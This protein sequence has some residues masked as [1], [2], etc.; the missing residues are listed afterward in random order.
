LNDPSTV[1]K[2][3]GYDV[4]PQV[5]VAGFFIDLGVR[6]PPSLARS[7]SALNATV[8]A[9]IQAGPPEIA[10]ACARKFS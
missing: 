6:I 2:E 3:K 10:T 9:I 8:Q 7:C 4:V 1:L 5:G